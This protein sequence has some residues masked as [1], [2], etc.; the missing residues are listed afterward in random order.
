MAG[1]FDQNYYLDLKLK[2][3][4]SVDKL[5][6]TTNQPYTK[7]G[8]LAAFARA[9]LTPEQHYE[10]FGRSESLN[11]NPYFNEYEYLQAKVNQ[12]RSVGEKD[13]GGNDYTRESLVRLLDFL[14][15]TPAEHYERYGSHERDKDNNFINP[16]NSF[17]ANGYYSAKLAELQAT[18]PSWTIDRLVDALK[19]SGLSPVSHYEAFGA[20][21]AEVSGIPMVQT[22]PEV[23]RVYDDKTREDFGEVVPQNPAPATVP[24]VGND[25]G[26]K[27][28]NPADVGQKVPES[29]SPPVERPERNLNPAPE[30]DGD[31]PPAGDNPPGDDGGGVPNLVTG[32]Q[33]DKL[34]FNGTATQITV[35]INGA[36]L[37]FSSP[38]HAGHSTALADF[39]GLA[40]G[41]NQNL[42]LN[43][44]AAI[45]ALFTSGKGVA[46]DGKGGLVLDVTSITAGDLAGFAK[47]NGDENTAALDFQNFAGKLAISGG[48]HDISRGERQFIEGARNDASSPHYKAD[49]EIDYTKDH[50]TGSD[51]IKAIEVNGATLIATKGQVSLLDGMTITGNGNVTIKA[52]LGAKPLGPNPGAQ[53][54]GGS[55]TFTV[56]TTGRNYIAAGVGRD[57]IVL[58]QGTGEDTL[59]FKYNDSRYLPETPWWD[60][61]HNFQTDGKDKLAFISMWA[62]AAKGPAKV[63]A[64]GVHTGQG[65]AIGDFTANNGVITHTGQGSDGF[66]KKTVL[67]RIGQIL[68]ALDATTANTANGLT[69]AN[70]WAYVDAASK[71]AG[72]S[73]YILKVDGKPG[74]N[75]DYADGGGYQNDTP[76]NLVVELV[77]VSVSGAELA[78]MLNPDVSNINW[79]SV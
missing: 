30:P 16:S 46:V 17:D 33:N 41:E 15:L 8:L 26:R 55:E 52:D 51:K 37:V 78:G 56:Q 38:G 65:I 12:L 68:D 4:T 74:N 20:G 70:V 61:V 25:K 36:D 54:S 48:I 69:A 29:L 13:G 53:P 58:G 63:F 43:T 21:E 44:F 76:G 73:T 22:V 7:E 72:Q 5:D 47:T 67:Q 79:G 14:G 39:K 1:F 19:E 64:A 66:A 10:K 49:T 71:G 27:V 3:L 23:S 40:L 60:M 2:Q 42:H 75:A 18:D 45:A 9:G 35:D 24:P 57:T 77:G 50:V 34:L 62:G 28:A 32:R 6:S 11:P 31:N 59:I